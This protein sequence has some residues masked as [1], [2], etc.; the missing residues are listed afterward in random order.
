MLIMI[1]IFLSSYGEDVVRGVHVVDATRL[2]EV[3]VS[4]RPGI[5]VF[6]VFGLHIGHKKV[7]NRCSASA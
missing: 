6:Q 5:E 2:V 3:C 4:I 1:A 7:L